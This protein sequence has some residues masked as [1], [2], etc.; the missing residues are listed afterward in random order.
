M[1]KALVIG[2]ND[3]PDIPLEGCINDA[4][5]IKN[6]LE[7]NGD[8]TPNFS[9]IIETDVE[10]KGKLKGLIKELFNGNSDTALLYFSGHG[11]LDGVGGYLVTPD[12]SKDD[13]GVSMNE[14]LK[15]ANTSKVKN[16]IIILDCCHSGYFGNNG[17]TDD[18]ITSLN[19][20][21]TILT[22]SKADESAVEMGGHGI[23]TT[24]LIDALH[25]GAAD[26]RGSITPGSVYSYIDQ[27]LGPWD[28]RPVFKTNITQFVSLKEVNPQ[29]P[30][31][32][33]RRLKEF[34]SNTQDIFELDPSFE[35]TN[36]PEIEHKTIE[37][38]TIPENADKFKILQRLESVG[39]VV[40]IGEEHMYFAAMN[41]KGCKMTALGCHYWRLVKEGRI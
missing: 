32:D 39:L 18:N 23:F 16:K 19:E 10:S 33:I 27:A 40:P 3:Y 13:Y 11:Y 1:R 15:L 28:Q 20:G 26:L 5:A 25:G 17:P 41:S 12:Y 14:I 6:A 22:A 7:R 31:H 34:F 37:P 2:I 38:Y 30:L 9:V 4:Y 35:N 21:I 29:V 24:L 8:G 36:S